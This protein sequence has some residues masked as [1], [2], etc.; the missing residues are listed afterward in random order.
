MKP[1]RFWPPHVASF[2][3]LLALP[4]TAA[5]P[6]PA[7]PAK[8]ETKAEA[9]VR[10]SVYGKL[11][12][13][14][15]NRKGLIMTADN[16]DRLAWRVETLVLERLREVK[17]GVPMIVIYRQTQPNEKI[18]TAVAFPGAADNPTYVNTTG[19]RVILHS[20]PAV[21]GACERAEAVHQ[22]PIIE[23][24]Q[25]ETG[26]ACWCCAPADEACHPSTKT[27]L[28]RAFLVRCF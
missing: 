14:D 7:A 5:A 13:V 21:D 24:G 16:G 20:G 26:D 28:G 1:S 17:P 15:Q 4:A 19:A 6:P 3:L 8:A 18:V 27:G 11:E 25:A 23:G 10:K 22:V 12:S 9:P 2:A